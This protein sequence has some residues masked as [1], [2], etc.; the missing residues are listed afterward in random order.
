MTNS[1]A[2]KKVSVTVSDMKAYMD[3]EVQ[4]HSLQNAA[5]RMDVNSQPCARAA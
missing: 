4:P 1:N 2:P 3:V 5:Q